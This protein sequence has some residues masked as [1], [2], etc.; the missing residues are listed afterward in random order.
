M[1]KKKLSRAAYKEFIQILE[2]K[3]CIIIL[4]KM[5]KSYL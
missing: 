3:E 1:I 2:Y 5:L 4:E